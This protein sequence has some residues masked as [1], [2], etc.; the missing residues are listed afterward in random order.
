MASLTFEVERRMIPK[1]PEPPLDFD[2]LVLSAPKSRTQ[3]R[4]TLRLAVSAI[5]HGLL[6]AALVIIPLLSKTEMPEAVQ[7]TR[8]FFVTPSIAPPPPPPPPPP[9]G[10]PR[11][12]AVANVAREVDSRRFVA[13]IE[14]PGDMPVADG[15]DLGVE[16]GVVG[17]VEGGVA[18]GVVGGVV[19]GLP[20]VAPVVRPVR[21]GAGIREPRKIK[22]VDP[23]YPF[24]ARSARVQ[25]VVVLEC[26]VGVDG[27]VETAQVVQG[28]PLLDKAALEAVRQWRYTP[29]LYQGVPVPV[30]MTV[31]VT[32]ALTGGF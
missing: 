12:A 15:L 24:V 19:G 11:A 22:H 17:G 5:L 32:F 1:D 20:D 18:G 16:G 26:T 14:L 21:V 4:R 9:S 27:R 29:T 30:I 6:I 3:R 8:V 31:T 2:G 23:V 10:A 25:G 13:P 28:V 7:G